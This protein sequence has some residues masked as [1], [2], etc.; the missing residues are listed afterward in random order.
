LDNND[1]DS[2][3]T[4]NEDNDSVASH[5]DDSDEDGTDTRNYAKLVDSLLL[6]DDEPSVSYCFDWLKG[7]GDGQ[8]S[9]KG[10]PPTSDTTLMTEDEAK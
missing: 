6:E 1:E 2:D 4:D 8:K 3:D 9:I 5:D 10:Q 7:K